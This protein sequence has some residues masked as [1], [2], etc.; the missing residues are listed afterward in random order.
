MDLFDIIGPVMVGPSSSHTAGATRIGLIAMRLFG[1]MPET[2]D[3][4]LHGSFAATGVGHGTQ[5]ALIAGLMGMEPDDPSIPNS[6]AIARERGLTVRFLSEDLGEVH[7]NTARLTLRRDAR[8]MT[9]MASSVGGGRIRVR[10]LDGMTVDFSGENHTL[11]IAHEDETGR[12]ATVSQLLALHGVN[13]A[14]LQDFRDQRGGTAIMVVETDQPVKESLLRV[15]A[16]VPGMR[17]VS[18]LEN[19]VKPDDTRRASDAFRPVPVGFTGMG[20]ADRLDTLV[21]DAEAWNADLCSVLLWRES[22]AKEMSQDQIFDRMAD[23]YRV[24]K[25]VRSQYDPNERSRS[26]LIGGEGAAME[27]ALASGR[28]LSRGLYGDVIAEALRHSE[29]N[30]CMKRIVAAPTAGS[31]GVLPAVLLSVQKDRGYDD[32]AMVRA[33]VVAAGVGQVLATRASIAGAEGGCQAEVG[34]ASAMAAAALTYLEGGS[35]RASMEAAGMALSNLMGLVCDPVATLVEVPCV[36]RNVI[37]S[38][39]A[40]AA[41]DM[42]LAGITLKIPADE[43]VDAMKRV[44]RALPESLRETGEGGLAGTPTGIALRRQILGE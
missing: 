35:P 20:P 32:D 44:G 29:C 19:P 17:R 16:A 26:G 10:E 42:A 7:P 9:V 30:A 24:M 15:I 11:V 33:L 40:L 3:I 43:V 12:I 25:S 23:A 28:A 34:S 31:C 6:P 4:A 8:E 14:T 5:N 13:I 21:A 36:K 41:A 27:A 37:G 38:V 1:C 39:G 22:R 18:A 2:C